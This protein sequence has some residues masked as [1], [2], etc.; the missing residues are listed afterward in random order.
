MPRN[1]YTEC[2]ESLIYFK[3]WIIVK[4]YGYCFF[5]LLTFE[6]YWFL[7][8]LLSTFILDGNNVVGS[9]SINALMDTV[10]Y[11]AV[12]FKIFQFLVD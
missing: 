8:T 11:I 3:M 5:F 4:D 1:L 9:F 6:N 10:C 7:S 12:A 2:M